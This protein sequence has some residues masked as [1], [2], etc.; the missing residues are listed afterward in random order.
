[1]Y[2]YRRV[3][4]TGSG[5]GIDQSCECRVEVG[6]RTLELEIVRAVA[7]HRDVGGA[8]HRGRAGG[9]DHCDLDWG[10]RRR[11]R[12]R[13]EQRHRKGPGEIQAAGKETKRVG[14]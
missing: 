10:A 2:V 14:C 5:V 8:A 13:V 9:A 11:G 3:G 7:R 4:T 12:G 1:M 6:Q